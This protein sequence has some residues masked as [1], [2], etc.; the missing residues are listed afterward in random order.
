M[1]KQLFEYELIPELTIVNQYIAG[2]QNN[3]IGNSSHTHIEM[4]EIAIF[5]ELQLTRTDIQVK[6]FKDNYKLIGL[7]HLK[8]AT[9]FSTSILDQCGLSFKT[10]LVS[11][12]MPQGTEIQFKTIYTNQDPQWEWHI[13]SLY[14][15]AID[16]ILGLDTTPVSYLILMN[17]NQTSKT[18]R[19]IYKNGNCV[20]KVENIYITAVGTRWE[21]QISYHIWPDEGVKNYLEYTLLLYLANCYK[22]PYSHFYS[23]LL[24]EYRSID[25][26]Q[27]MMPENI[28]SRVS[29]SKEEKLK[30]MP[31]YTIFK[32]DVLCKMPRDIMNKLVTLT[33]R[34]GSGGFNMETMMDYALGAFHTYNIT[35]THT[36]LQRELQVRVGQISETWKSKCL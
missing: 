33:K 26:D 20:P 5:K 30:M 6:V 17:L 2:M 11:V 25:T 3:S 32:K 31:S 1:K 16:M 22:S 13:R 27:C 34:S 36:Q 8:T 19:D 24:E 28:W 15:T 7:S 10:K 9:V 35:D 12:K 21:K 23:G 29:L 18:F 4:P 14:V